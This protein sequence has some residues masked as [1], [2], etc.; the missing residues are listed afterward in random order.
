MGNNIL[1]CLESYLAYRLLVRL[2][3]S[4]GIGKENPDGLYSTPFSL[5]GGFVIPFL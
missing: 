5:G 4:F 2:W 1:F 3:V